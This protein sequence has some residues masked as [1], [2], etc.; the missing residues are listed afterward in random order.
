MYIEIAVAKG[1]INWEGCDSHSVLEECIENHFFTESKF[2]FLN[3]GISYLIFWKSIIS[4][5]VFYCLA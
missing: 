2:C 1:K 4:A 5:I 3:V